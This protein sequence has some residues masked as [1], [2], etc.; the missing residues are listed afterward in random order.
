M[1]LLDGEP[2]DRQAV[3]TPARPAAHARHRGAGRRCARRRAHRRHPASRRE[4]GEH[5]HHAARLREGARLRP[6][7]A[8]ARIPPLGAAPRCAGTRRASPSTSPAWP[9][10][11]SAPSPTCR[12]NRRAATTWIRARIC[13]R[14]AWCC[15]RWRPAGRAF[16]GNTTAVVFDGILN[17]EPAPPS[18]LNTSLPGELDRIVSKALEKDRSLRYQTAADLGA[19]LKRLRRD[20]GSRQIVVPAHEQQPECRH[21]RAAV[22]RHAVSPRFWCATRGAAIERNAG[23][24]GGRSTGGVAVGREQAVGV[25]GRR[26]PRARRGHCRRHRRVLCQPRRRTG[27]GRPGTTGRGHAAGHART[28][29][30]G[31]PG[32]AGPPP[33]AQRRRALPRRLRPRLPLPRSRRRPP[34]PSRQPVVPANAG[35]DGAGRSRPSPSRLR[36]PPAPVVSRDAE[37]M[38]RLE[39]ARAKVANNLNDQALTDLRQIIVD[40]P[41]S[42]A[43]AEAS[44]LVGGSAREGRPHRRCDGRAGGVRKPI[45]RRSPR[46]RQQAAPLDDA[47]PACG[48]RGRKRSRASCW[49]RWRAS[50]PARRRQRPR[51]TPS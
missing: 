6:R 23:H 16:P 49:P 7:Q 35:A 13:S 4:A 40:Y 14:S 45:R 28:D 8:V 29:A 32:G 50:F 38:Q 21:R 9:A 42:R 17:R 37:A 44:L 25:R 47:R 19:D 43:A 41:G 2:L 34:R 15:T 18:S 36:R 11:P 24:V 31:R 46:G 5:L 20:S 39:V 48:S 3:G 22:R 30:G 10:P 1:E 26:R 27:N 12:R 51:S 33:A